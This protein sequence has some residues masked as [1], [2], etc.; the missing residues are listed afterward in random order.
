MHNYAVEG[1]LRAAR[2]KAETAWGRKDYLPVVKAL[3]PLRAALRAVEVGKLE[4][5][6]KQCR[7]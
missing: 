6:E 4:F 7:Q 5:A 2:A 3:S 1:T